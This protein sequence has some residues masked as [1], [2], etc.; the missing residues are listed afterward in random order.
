M[1]N[2]KIKNSPDC[3]V[4]APADWKNI[5]LT[6]SVL[7]TGFTEFELQTTGML[8]TYYETVSA[9]SDPKSVDSF[10]SE[11]S[12]ILRDFGPFEVAMN[13]QIEARLIK[14]APFDD[15]A[16]QIMLLW[17]TGI[18]TTAGVPAMVNTSA[19]FQGL[20]WQAANTHPAG[21]L[22][23]GYGSWAELPLT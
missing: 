7:L 4:E 23:P 20:I 6:I 15:L 22:Q 16:R 13:E 12:K 9:N 14:Q 2:K 3:T 19:Y 10:A 5:F 1:A 8:D 17:Y 18:W 11:V 21:A